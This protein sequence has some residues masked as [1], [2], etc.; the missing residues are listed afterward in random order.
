M[1]LVHLELEAMSGTL[2]LSAQTKAHPPLSPPKDPFGRGP[3]LQPAEGPERRFRSP[4][5]LFFFFFGRIKP[6]SDVPKVSEWVSMN[7]NTFANLGD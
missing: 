5:F 1:H 2:T 7:M 4:H 3:P 6:S